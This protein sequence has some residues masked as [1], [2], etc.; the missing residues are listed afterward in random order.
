[1]N[2]HKSAI[3]FAMISVVAIFLILGYL[4]IQHHY[5]Y[6][7]Y[8][9]YGVHLDVISQ[10]SSIGIPGQINMYEAK[11]FNFTVLPRNITGCDYISDTLEPGTAFPYG[12]QRWN[13]RTRSW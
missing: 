11:L 4:E 10:P 2:T 5:N 6:G 8:F 1:M 7:H 13:D 12:V 9:T 3:K